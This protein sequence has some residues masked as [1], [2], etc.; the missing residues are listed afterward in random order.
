MSTSDQLRK[1]VSQHSPKNTLSKGDDKKIAEVMAR[2]VEH[3]NERFKLDSL[4]YYLEYVPS[5]KLSE[6][7]GII[8]S[9]DKRAEFSPLTKEDSFI[10]PDGGILLLR[11]K[12]DSRVKKRCAAFLSGRAERDFEPPS[13]ISRD[14]P[15]FRF[16]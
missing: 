8:K 12:D 5:I 4:G 10:K 7:I 16:V 13:T 15:H 9:Y 1:N 6:L 2:L 3:L 14:F 11:K